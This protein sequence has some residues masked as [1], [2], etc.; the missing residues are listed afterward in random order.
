M[1]KIKEQLSWV[2]GYNFSLLSTFCHIARAEGW[3]EEEIEF[4]RSKCCYGWHV[5]VLED[6]C[7]KPIEKYDDSGCLMDD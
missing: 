5:S 7:E 6:Y 2:C 1:K 3:S 4:V